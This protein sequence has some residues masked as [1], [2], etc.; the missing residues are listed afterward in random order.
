MIQN[1]LFVHSL[2]RGDAVVANVEVPEVAHVGENL[3]VE[4]AELV[5]GEVERLQSR[6][7]EDVAL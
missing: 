4:A 7:V 5:G 3:P 6:E 1:W 2:D